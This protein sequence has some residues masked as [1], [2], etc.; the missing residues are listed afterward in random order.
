[1]DTIHQPKIAFGAAGFGLCVD[2]SSFISV[3]SAIIFGGNSYGMMGTQSHNPPSPGLVCSMAE[4]V[5]V[6]A[7]AIRSGYEL[8]FG[9]QYI[10]SFNLRDSTIVL[11]VDCDFYD[12]SN[13]VD[14]SSKEIIHKTGVVLPFT[15]ASKAKNSFAMRSRDNWSGALVLSCF[16]TKASCV[17]IDLLNAKGQAVSHIQ[18]EN[19]ESG[20][21]QFTVDLKVSR[22]STLSNSVYFLKVATSEN[23]QC[24]RLIS[25]R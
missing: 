25:V 14:G 1:M 15:N 2:T 16:L 5:S 24:F 17:T 10:E 23:R 22:A 4:S 20:A 6:S 12:A 19:M 3:D 13:V 9:Q 8:Y 11:F 21:H 7:S 18:R